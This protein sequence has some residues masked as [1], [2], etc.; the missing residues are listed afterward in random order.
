ME[1]EENKVRLPPLT[2]KRRDIEGE[3][4]QPPLKK[5]KKNTLFDFLLRDLLS[6]L[7]MLNRF[8]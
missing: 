2:F 3:S 5:K 1:K 6:L 4:A 8:H 7:K